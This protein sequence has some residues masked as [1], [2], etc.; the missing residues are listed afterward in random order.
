[1]SIIAVILAADRGG[2]FPGSKY[3]TPV[4]GVP[5]LEAVLAD[6]RLWPVD[7]VMVVLGSDADL[8]EDAV[9]LSAVS[10]VVDPEWEEGSASPLRAVLDFVSRDRSVERC[11]IARGDQPGVE[12]S[13]VTALL[14]TATRSDAAAVI[15][16][17]RYA[18]GFPV[19]IDASMWDVFLG[20]EGTIDILDVISNHASSIEEVWFDHLQ[21]APVA[22][23]DDVPPA[24]R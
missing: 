4:R 15:P 23:I 10:V 14:D 13:I 16:K 19:V 12:G 5:L 17:Y 24:R 7:D 20:L 22:T 8:L 2:D 6:A 18:V 3:L 9:D 21:P 1:M 11:V